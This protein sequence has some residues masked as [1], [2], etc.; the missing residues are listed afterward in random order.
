MI[1]GNKGDWS[2]IYV[3]LKL[4]SDKVLVPGDEKIQ[5]I[6]DVF[7]PII[8]ILRTE[9]SGDFEYSIH[10]DIVVISG[11]EEVLRIPI[12]VFKEKAIYLLEY[13]KSSPDGAF[14]VPEIENFM[15]SINCISLKASSSVKTDITIVIHDQRT[16]QQPILGFSVKS[17]LGSASTL[18]NAVQSSNFIYE[19]SG[20]KMSEDD[21]NEI[22]SLFIK[23]GNKFLRDVKGR[24]KAILKKEGD[25]LFIG[26]EKPVFSNNLMLIDSL[27][28]QILS[29]IIMNYYSG[30]AVLISE[31][32][33]NI[34]KMNPL[35]FDITNNHEFY[36]YKMK[37]FLTDT[38]LGMLPSKVWNGKYDATGGY[39]VV[40]EDGDVLCYHL[41]NRNEFENYLLS[42]TKLET[43]STSRH[44][45]GDLYNEEGKI[46]FKLNLQIRFIK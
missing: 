17:Q 29:E 21:I 42:N 12:E 9:T 14:S 7:Y 24:T 26:V 2:E 46:F 45:F 13:I 28:P 23:R 19:V 39:L 3:L 30:N 6:P 11:N 37:R 38:A 34:E 8:K 32:V 27:L 22:N 43:P 16:N 44:R 41:Y 15:S 4:L 20:I 1:T 31:L 36:R 18:F 40:K 25:L 35:S 33:N 10:D 5:R